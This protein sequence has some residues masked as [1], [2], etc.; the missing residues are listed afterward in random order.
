[1]NISYNWLKQ[2]IHTDL[3][4]DQIARILTDI[5]L[6]VE[7][8]ETVESVRG[9]LE[10]V[11]VGEVLTC[12]KHP[13][14]DKLHL[15]TVDIGTGE[16]LQIVCGAPNVAAGQKVLV[17]TVGTTL[18]PTGEENG[19]KI[20]KSKIRGVESLGMLCA[21][22]ELGIGTD[23]E[24]IMVLD[25][26]ARAGM[27]A[28][29]W[30]QLDSD[31][32]IAIGLTPNRIDAASHYGVARDLAAYLR[33]ND[34][35]SELALPSVDAFAADNHDRATQI[36]VQNAEAAPRYTG[37]T[38]TGVK[39][40]PSP[41]WLQKRLR[42]IG[43]NPHNNVVDVTNFIL[44]E[45]GQPMH[46]F[47]ADKIDG[48]RVVVRTC[49]EG[50]P[51][52]TLDGVE[53][54]LSAQDL[55]ICSATRPMCIAG[56]FG[57]LDSGVTEATTNV[58]LESAYFNPVW[59][60]KTAR[61]HGL[62]TDASFRY[63]RGTDPNITVYAIKRAALLI[64]EIAGGTISSEITDIYPSPVEPFRFD[65]SFDRINRLIGKTIPEETV[66]RI[67]A[68]LEITIEHE[69]NGV[70]S[71]AVPSYRVDVRREADLIE[72]ILRIYGYNNVEIPQHVNSTLSYA[73]NP[74]KDKLTNSVADFL[75]SNGFTEIMSNSLT[76]AA[77]YEGLKAYPTDQ[78]VR[79]LNPLSGDL[80]VMRQT[81]LFN[82]M[83][84]VALNTNRKNAN[85]KLYEFGNC[86]RYN[87]AKAEAGGLAPYE[88]EA[89]LALLVTGAEHTQSWNSPA[90][91]ASFFTLK[92]MAEKILRRFGQD[93]YRLSCEPLSSDLYSEAVQFKAGK[94]LFEIG[95][96]SA[97]VRKMFDIKAPVYYMEMNF[98]A[99]MRMTKKHKVTAEE[100]SKF[101]EVKR[102]L[103]LLVD[104]GVS[105]GQLRSIAFST[106][107]KLL[108]S[109]SLFDVYEGDKLPEGKKSYALSFVLED[110]T[111][112]LTDA[113]IDRT[114]NNL[115]TQFERHVGATVRA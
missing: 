90:A 62:N 83:E 50:T 113:V 54:K 24:G 65:I 28:R 26:T 108:R 64:R 4:P 99:L 60:R 17:A 79:I 104:E 86:Y 15:T 51:F 71:V 75:T 27:P 92:A 14:A 34:L 36:E 103:A 25:A 9:G 2:Y 97:K 18:Y 61:R 106:E 68:S 1:M 115:I 33:V 48:G 95:I 110:K 84:A 10:G 13:D 45:L 73:P 94:K 96:V 5:G 38:I 93:I 98:D 74:D 56:V 63:E 82:A 112:T 32:L 49:D 70:L 6:E 55:M 88:E 39:V 102:D 57:G 101:P 66:K 58:F 35:S 42:A 114:M 69:K 111:Q 109:V 107:K 44:H 41:E 20:K 77:Y 47:D 80:S 21:E 46:A 43:L 22:D 100:L 19:F 52:T 3:G 59:V 81:L 91:P 85:L 89:R 37:L 40:G 67:I 29:E 7:G 78:C 30:L 87:A 105:F 72:D 12:D 53:R 31:V 76:K 23:H 16:P 8:I 11:V